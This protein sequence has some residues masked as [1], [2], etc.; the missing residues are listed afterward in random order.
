MN[1]DHNNYKLGEVVLLLREMD[2]RNIE[3][4]E[5]QEKVQAEILAQT[6]KTN[7]RVG[8]LEVWRGFITGG[9]AIIGVLLIPLFLRIL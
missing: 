3:K 5:A 6:K 8:N 1:E 4:H 2:K 7:G 9:L